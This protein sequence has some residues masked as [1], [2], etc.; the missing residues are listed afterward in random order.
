MLEHLVRHKTYQ[1]YE[2]YYMIWNRGVGEKKI[3]LLMNTYV[4]MFLVMEYIKYTDIYDSVINSY[5]RWLSSGI[6]P[7]YEENIEISCDSKTGIKITFENDPICCVRLMP[8]TQHEASHFCNNAVY[9]NHTKCFKYF[10][11][12]TRHHDAKLQ[13]LAVEKRNIVFT[14]I[15]HESGCEWHEKTMAHAATHGNL[16]AMKYLYENGVRFCPMTCEYALRYKQ[17][18][19]LKYAVEKGAFYNKISLLYVMMWHRAYNCCD[20]V[21]SLK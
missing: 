1:F 3:S 5:S 12:M 19:C 17:L 18:D 15:L 21:D 10:Y 11:T 16:D 13:F 7:L 2:L 20:Y 6:E 4:P 8:Q 9:L 14:K